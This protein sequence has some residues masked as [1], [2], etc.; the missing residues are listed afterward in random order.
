MGGTSF[1]VA[2]IVDGEPRRNIESEVHGYVVRT[3]MLDIRSIGAGGGSLAWIDDGGALQVGPQSAGSEPGPVCYGRGGTQPAV[4]DANAVLGYLQDLT[5]G[6][7]AL[8]VGAARRALAQQIGGPLGPD[9]LRGP[10]AVY[11]PRHAHLAGAVP[12]LTTEAAVSPP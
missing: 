9:A 6:S 12:G 5:G 7:F 3:P 8:D 2:V 1:D 11:P 4:S 10:P